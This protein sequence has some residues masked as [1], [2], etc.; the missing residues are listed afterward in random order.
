M[1]YPTG[2][3]THMHSG[4]KITAIY[5][6]FFNENILLSSASFEYANKNSLDVHWM[7]R[8]CNCR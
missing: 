1:L 5:V 4:D 6:L 7:Q 2:D 3:S 8:I